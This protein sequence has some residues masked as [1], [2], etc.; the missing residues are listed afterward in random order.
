MGNYKK[1][2][3]TSLL[4]NGLS[5]A[6]SFVTGILVARSLGPE[7]KGY[8]A[9][10]IM[11]LTLIV[12]YGHFGVMNAMSYF[13]KRT[14]HK[15]QVI[16]STNLAYILLLLL[17]YSVILMYLKSA[18]IYFSEYA[19]ID[20]VIG[21]FF[22]LFSFLYLLLYQLSVGRDEVYKINKF[23]SYERLAYLAITAVLFFTGQLT[24]MSYFISITVIKG[25]KVGAI[26]IDSRL[27]FR[28]KFDL[29]LIKREFNYGNLI[30]LASFFHYLNYRVDQFM[31]NHM[32]GKSELGIYS[33]GVQL[34]E[35]AL[36]I[37]ASVAAPLLG[38]LLNKSVDNKKEIKSVTALTVKFTLYVTGVVAIIGILMSP[39]VTILYG[40]PFA[41]SS[42]VLVVLLLGI[43]A[44]SIGKVA[45][46]YY[47]SI[48]KP[49]TPLVLAFCVFLVNLVANIFFIP[50]YGILGAAL[51]STISYT[52]F[53]IVYVFILKYKELISLKDL[54]Y[55][56]RNDIKL[57]VSTIRGRK[58][59]KNKNNN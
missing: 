52:F 54:I 42:T 59:G 55:I 28:P 17:V 9:Y 26:F 4:F 10:L 27:G 31:I 32:L 37:P 57:A 40:E 25:L 43:V 20:F 50:K 45:P 8:I 34:A 14:K 1:N 44:A 39:L 51:A 48:G 13:M 33:V 49:I 5:L 2:I 56:N 53:G 30:F 15:E 24:I 16:F 22:I 18:D 35:L 36:L 23:H 29:N 58:N 47:V 7:G 12:N 38:N 46:S 11:I 21:F 19:F 41:R 6:V 3:S